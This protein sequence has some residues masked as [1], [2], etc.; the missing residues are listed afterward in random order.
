M[1]IGSAKVPPAERQG[2]PHHLIDLVEPSDHL[3]LARFLDAANE[4]L[5]DVWDRGRLP[6]LAGG[7]GQYVWALL[8]GWQPP[9]VPPDPALRAELD[10]VAASQGPEVLHDKLAALDPDAAAKLDRRNAR[11][12]I[13]AL[14]VVMRTGKTLAACQARTPIDADSLILG[15][16]IDREAL[17][18]RLDA[19]VDAMFA[20]GLIAEVEALRAAGYGE[21]VPVRG[22]A[23]YREVSEFLDGRYSFEEAVRRTKHAHHR[24]VRRQAAWF[25]E[26]D[27]RIHWIEAGDR[28]S[29]VASEAV[30]AWLG[31][32]ASG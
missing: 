12:I 32:A 27:P 24:L 23:G 14:E 15:L 8:E 6:V 29:T 17:Y 19:R 31:T 28:A 26:T 18:R 11:R 13:R 5:R 9:R 30:R 21:S 2:I 4:A 22:A 16:R 10:A 3:T 7:S 25:R 1:D 20:A